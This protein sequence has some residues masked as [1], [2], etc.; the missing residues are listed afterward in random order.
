MHCLNMT[1]QDL[2][3]FDAFTLVGP[4][5]KKH[6]AHAWRLS[7][8]L[9]EMDH[10]SIS[11]ALVA[12]TMSTHYDPMYSNLELSGWL[13]PHPHLFPI[14]NAMPHQTGEFPDP[15][16]FERLRKR[17]GVRAVSV[18]PTTNGWNPFSGHSR[19]LLQSLEKERC[20]TIVNRREFGPSWELDSFLGS[21]PELPVLLT[22][23]RWN[24]QR[25][26]LPLLANHR[27]LHLSFD[28]FH[29]N[30]GIEDLVA[31]GH[32][33]QLIFASNAPTMSMGAH[34]AYID[35]AEVPRGAQCKI[36]GGNLMRLL[37]MEAPPTLRTN[38]GEDALMSAARAGKSL[39]V[40]VI[41]MHMHI[42]H[43]GMHGAGG[44]YRMSKGGPKPTLHRLKQLGCVGGGFMSWNGPVSG[45]SLGGNDCVRQALDASPS[46]YWGLASFNTTHFTQQE[47]ERMIAE[48]YSDRRFIGMKPYTT[49]GVEYHHPS[50][51]L[52]WRYG[53]ER[54]F[55]AG[56]HRNRNDF[57][58][59]KTLARKYPRVRWVVYH[60]GSDYATADQAIECMREFPNVYAEITLTSVPLGIIDY[61]VEHA[62]TDRILYGSDLPMRDPRQQLGWVV[63]SRLPLEVKTKI[64][65][66]NALEVIAPFADEIFKSAPS[67]V[68][69]RNAA[70]LAVA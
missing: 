21:F 60:C 58:E 46:G 57:L 70:G 24:E 49:Q 10:C 64:L 2:L 43:E 39:P 36:A 8:L 9:A 15:D 3:Y 4:R 22:A 65:S 38:A 48:V 19:V 17:H 62:G 16:E 40:P 31:A 61:L 44:N 30:Y 59:V 54:A 26:V 53:N 13:E 29:I 69:R 33:D 6:P 27:N 66:S 47:L 45:D 5:A 14:W 23:V 7:E 41:D 18:H 12:S 67:L 52:W 35:Y 20:L 42:L 56:I 25:S 68:S 55:Y 32:E 34:R 50:Y 28:E 11:A 51:D 1:D 37:K 63:Y